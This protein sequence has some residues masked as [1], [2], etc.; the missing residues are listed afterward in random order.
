MATV[1]PDR[2]TA[3]QAAV[4]ATFQVNGIEVQDGRLVFDILPGEDGKERFLRLREHLDPIGVLPMLRR[5]QGRTVILLAP[6]PPQTRLQWALPVALFVATLASTFFAGYLNGTGDGGPGRLTPWASGVAFSLP[7]MAILFC[8]EMGHKLVSI[9]RGIDAG[10]PLFIPMAPPFGTMGA[11]ILMRTP[12]PNRDA[13]VDLGASGPIA[14]FLV[15][16]PVLIYGIAHSTVIA[17]PAAIHG[18]QFPSPKLVDFLIAR[19]LHPDPSAD[20]LF[21]PAAFAGWFGLLVT[22][23]NLLPGSMLDGG[24]VTRAVFGA[25][26]HLVLSIAAAV[27]AFV[28]KYWLMGVLILLLLRRGHPGPLDDVSPVTLS[29]KIIAAA[30]VVIFALSV[31]P[32]GFSCQ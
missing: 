32:L 23:I 11:V 20:V 15:A 22:A 26:A 24:H 25:R 3:I 16:I 1:A 19:L 18:C 21:H 2:F 29:R 30:L 5:R 10:L 7:L 8:H 17:N 9:W 28:F 31:V 13:L 14:G 12:A 4:E 27:V 6:K